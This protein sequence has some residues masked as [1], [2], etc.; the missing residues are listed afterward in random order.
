MAAVR[1]GASGIDALDLEAQAQP[2]DREPR[3]AEE[4]GGAGEGDAVIGAEGRRQSEVFE[5][6]LK[7]GEGVTLL[8]VSRASQEKSRIRWPA[9]GPIS[10]ADAAAAGTR[11]RKACRTSS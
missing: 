3:E 6:A 5:K 8:G 2:P 10:A 9:D 11:R 7:D 1:L 4:R